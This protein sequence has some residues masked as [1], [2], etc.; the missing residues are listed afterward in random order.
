M[1]VGRRDLTIEEESQIEGFL[2]AYPKHDGELRHG[3]M[4]RAAR[5]FN[6]HRNTVR[7]VWERHGSERPA[8]SGLV[9]K[10]D[11]V[12]LKVAL[13]AVP[14]FERINVRAAASAIA[15]PKSTMQEYIGPACPLRRVNV[16]VRPT[17]TD[18]HT[19]ERLRFVVTYVER[20]IGR[21]L[22]PLATALWLTFP[23]A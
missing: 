15:M 21:R 6:C 9:R 12:E 23:K 20:P 11:A 19:F 16:H 14:V 8:R 17:L 4:S 3:A 10:Y 18:E 13:Q 1:T 7:A 5:E 22:Y 2:L